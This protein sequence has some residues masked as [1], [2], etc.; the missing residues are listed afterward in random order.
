MAADDV[1]QLLQQREAETRA[2]ESKRREATY[3]STL[4]T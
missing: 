3:T 4:E 2:A 1:E